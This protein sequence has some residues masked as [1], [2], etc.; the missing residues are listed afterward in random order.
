[1]SECRILP[2]CFGIILKSLWQLLVSA[3][4]RSPVESEWGCSRLQE[5]G[6]VCEGGFVG[7][8]R[9]HQKLAEEGLPLEMSKLNLPC[10]GGMPLRSL[11]GPRQDCRQRQGVIPM[12]RACPCPCC[13]PCEGI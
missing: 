3:P 2:I 4:D 6:I 10:P 7:Q 5:A 1:M 13:Q 9:Q 11:V 12:Q 8:D